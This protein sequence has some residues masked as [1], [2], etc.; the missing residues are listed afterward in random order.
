MYLYLNIKSSLKQNDKNLNSEAKLLHKTKLFILHNIAENVQVWNRLKLNIECWDVEIFLRTD[1]I[2]NIF[3]NKVVYRTTG[4]VREA[5]KC[6]FLFQ[7]KQS[8]FFKI[9]KFLILSIGFLW[10]Y[11][12]VFNGKYRLFVNG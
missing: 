12:A 7:R 6:A 5:N 4:T 3:N 10:G 8:V 11:F 2:S 1:K 9:F